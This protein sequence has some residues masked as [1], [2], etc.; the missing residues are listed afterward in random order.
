MPV[1][2]QRVR[3]CTRMYLAT[4]DVNGTN[5][6]DL[7]LKQVVRISDRQPTAAIWVRMWIW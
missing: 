5:A 3:V 7:H 4:W 6:M 1:T 2:G